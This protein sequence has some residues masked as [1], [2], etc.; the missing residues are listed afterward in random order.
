MSQLEKVSTNNITW[1]ENLTRGAIA[2]LMHP[3]LPLKETGFDYNCLFS[4]RNYCIVRSRCNLEFGHEGHIGDSNKQNPGHLHLPKSIFE[5]FKNW[6]I[7][8][9][10]TRVNSSSLLHNMESYL[11][12]FYV[13]LRNYAPKTKSKCL[14]LAG[15]LILC[16]CLLTYYLIEDIRKVYQYISNYRRK[17]KLS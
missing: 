13:Y 10:K 8:I 2:V 5:T 16:N 9:S 12:Q 7:P 3:F 14:L 4:K 15:Q 1:V 17:L 6:A 11:S